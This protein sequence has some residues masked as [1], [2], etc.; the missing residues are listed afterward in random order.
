MANAL[1]CAAANASLD[2]SEREPRLRQVAILRLRSNAVW[3]LAAVCPGQGRCACG[4]GRV[5]E[6]ERIEDLDGLRA[7]FVRR[8][9]HPAFAPSST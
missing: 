7:G 6:L 8:G 3:R 4:R 2:C 1:A 5:V 9:V